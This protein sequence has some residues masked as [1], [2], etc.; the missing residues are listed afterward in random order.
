MKI[1]V[2]DKNNIFVFINSEYLTE[3]DFKSK[4]DIIFTVKDFIQT[5]KNKL[6]LRGFYK[7][8]VY[9]N[10]KVGLFLDIIR[11]EEIELSN[12]VDLRVIVH[13]DDKI[14]F[15]TEDYDIIPNHINKYYYNHK[16]YCDA[17]L[18]PNILKVVE[19]GNFIYGNHMLDILDK[20][21]VV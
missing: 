13:M 20:A 10:K 5:Y 17:S 14:Y 21:I 8:R 19:F 12:A 2:I 3:E 4:E 11:L 1:E 7:I 9:V 18:I 16:F 15:E 6:H